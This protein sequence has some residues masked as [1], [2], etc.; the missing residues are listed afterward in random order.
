MSMTRLA[1]LQRLQKLAHQDC[2][3]RNS[4]H[5]ITTLHEISGLATLENRFKPLQGQATKRIGASELMTGLKQ[6]I[7]LLAK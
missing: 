4:T 7:I 6:M 3:I 2:T 1:E 5:K